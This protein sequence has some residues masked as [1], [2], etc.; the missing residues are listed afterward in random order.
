MDYERWTALS[1]RIKGF[2]NSVEL[3]TREPNLLEGS[4]KDVLLQAARQIISTIGDT[5]ATDR[6]QLGTVL[7]RF[8]LPSIPANGNVMSS[9][10]VQAAIQLNSLV[11]EVDFSLEDREEPIRLTTERALRHLQWQIAAEPDVKTKWSNAF[12]D[13]EVACERLGAVHLLWHGI[14][15]F[16]AKSDGAATDL[17]LGEPISPDIVRAVQ[18][19]VLTEWKKVPDA[20]EAPQ[21]AGPSSG[22]QLFERFAGDDRA[23]IV[24]VHHPGL[25]ASNF[26]YRRRGY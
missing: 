20:L 1:A 11:S 2:V 12:T 22:Q 6:G 23:Q 19:L 25:S 9:V 4:A 21:L 15:S 24:S 10:V 3:L 5:V 17:V 14:C 18:G 26:A 7:A 8:T 13:G 16:K